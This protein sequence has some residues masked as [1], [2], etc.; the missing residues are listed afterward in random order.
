MVFKTTFSFDSRINNRDF[1]LRVHRMLSQGE[2]SLHCHEFTELVIVHGGKGPHCV[3]EDQPRELVRGN[4]FIIPKGAYH[5]YHAGDLSLVNILFETDLLP[6]P[7]LDIH[8]IPYFNMIFKGSLEAPEILI[9][10]DD[11]LQ[12]VLSLVEKLDA[13]ITERS[14]GCQFAATALFMQLVIYLARKIGARKVNTSS[15]S[16]SISQVIEHIHRHFKE[17]ISIPEL[18]SRAGMSMSS[19]LRHFKRI[20]GS[21]PKEYILGLRV[22]YA[23]ELLG[24][25]SSNISQIAFQ[26][27]FVDSNYFS[28]EFRR[29]TGKTPSEYRAARMTRASD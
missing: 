8:A 2:T 18:A 11:E 25:T 5:K 17:K 14:P 20:N 9:I 28:R 22:N 12:E 3:G 4:V 24:H 6:M 15:K 16:V 21:S 23:C 19:L 1:P 26:A 27:G 7:L 13:E 29:M 10:T